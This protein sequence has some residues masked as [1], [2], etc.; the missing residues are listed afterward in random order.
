MDSIRKEFRRLQ[1]QLKKVEIPT[2]D[3]LK[4]QLDSILQPMWHKTANN[5]TVQ[6]TMD[7][8]GSFGTS[9]LI[10]AVAKVSPETATQLEETIA[11][12]AKRYEQLQRRQRTA[13]HVE[14][15][16][17][18]SLVY[19][20]K[21]EGGVRVVEREVPKPGSE[22]ILVKVLA[23]GLNH[24]DYQKQKAQIPVVASVEGRGVGTDFCGVIEEL[25]WYKGDRVHTFPFALGKPVFGISSGTIAEYVICNVDSVAEFPPEMPPTE[26]AALPVRKNPKTC[27]LPPIG[28]GKTS[29]DSLL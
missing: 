3:D 9:Y 12:I 22:E 28:K 14:K 2:L 21:A 10:P 23:V 25:G 18:K 20:K 6:A 4:A 24:R 13:P 26:G 19:D 8:L 15:S 16:K 29:T 5:E 27:S 7:A 17:M 11:T 1:K